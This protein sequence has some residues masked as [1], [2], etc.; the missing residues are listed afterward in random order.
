MV[1]KKKMGRPPKQASSADAKTQSVDKASTEVEV[2]PADTDKEYFFESR[3]AEDCFTLIKPSKVEHKDGSTTVNPGTVAQFDKYGWT[4]RSA[5]LA[6][7]LRQIME[8][9][10]ETG[11]SESTSGDGHHASI[12]RKVMEG[13]RRRGLPEISP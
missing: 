11:L 10:P 1:V 8:E 4:T 6:G 3:Y 12:L 7:V 5:H 13:R 9:R 2:L